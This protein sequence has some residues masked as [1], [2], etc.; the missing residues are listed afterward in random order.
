[1]A[2]TE[3]QALAEAMAK[4]APAGDGQPR[5]VMAIFDGES[6]G[7]LLH[8]FTGLAMQSLIDPGRLSARTSF[9]PLTADEAVRIAN[10]TVS[11]L[12][13]F[14]SLAATRTHGNG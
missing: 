9:N 2:Q 12:E 8:H 3:Q 6:R 5:Q 10:E 4:A 14:Y 11:A 13:R 1:M 7:M